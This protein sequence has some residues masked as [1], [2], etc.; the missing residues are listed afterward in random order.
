MTKYPKFKPEEKRGNRLTTQQINE[1]KSLFKSGKNAFQISKQMKIG[2]NTARRHTDPVYKKKSNDDSNKRVTKKYNSDPEYRKNTNATRA[3]NLLIQR[4]TYPKLN[5]Y[6]KEKTRE[7]GKKNR[8][9]INKN[10]KKYN[11]EHLEEKKLYDKT[12]WEQKTRCQLQ[13]RE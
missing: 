10:S 4:H 6:N 13:L 3:K 2:H 7:Y 11:K 9:K 8:K 1:I 12:R 5:E